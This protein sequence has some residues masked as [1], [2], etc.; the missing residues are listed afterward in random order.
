M[1]TTFHAVLPLD[2]NAKWIA[3][4]IGCAEALEKLEKTIEVNAVVPSGIHRLTFI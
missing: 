2:G 3:D 4:E 1:W